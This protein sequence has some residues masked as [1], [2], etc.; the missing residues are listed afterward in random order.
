MAAL[1][2]VDSSLRRHVARA[3]ARDHLRT[4]S[5]EASRGL[6][7]LGFCSREILLALRIEEAHPPESRQLWLRY[8]RQKQ[9]HLR[10]NLTQDVRVVGCRLVGNEDA[11]P[12]VR[13]PAEPWLGGGPRASLERIR[14]AIA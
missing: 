10:S 3:I 8:P 4:G 12:K 7:V 9:D 1:G 14:G 11:R 6:T 2:A 13:P 5:H